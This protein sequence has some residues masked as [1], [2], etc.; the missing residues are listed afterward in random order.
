QHGI[1]M[2]GVDRKLS[3]IANINSRELGVVRELSFE[4]TAPIVVA[5]PGRQGTFVGDR[6]VILA[7]NATRNPSAQSRIEMFAANTGPLQ[8]VKE[9]TDPPPKGAA[10]N[11]C[12]NRFNCIFSGFENKAIGNA[13]LSLRTEEDVQVLRVDNI[14]S[15]LSDGVLQ[16]VPE[17]MDMS[18]TLLTPNFSRS[19]SGAQL[20]TTQV[21][22]VGKTQN[23][24]FS[25]M[26][27]V[28]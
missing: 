2:S 25:K 11:Q 28:N 13:T 23:D 26:T 10:P 18:T 17:T 24:L 1:Y 15:S 4:T 12:F 14:G 6:F 22:V 7:Q 27:I 5:L 19:Q 8:I 21:G 16:E 20:V 3:T 9:T